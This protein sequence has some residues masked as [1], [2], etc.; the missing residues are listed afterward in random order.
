MKK[1]LA[2][3]AVATM[4]AACTNEEVTQVENLKDTPITI[5]SAG[6]GELT[7]SRTTT[8]DVVNN[9]FGLFVESTS[10]DAKYEASNMKWTHNNG[11]KSNETLLFEGAGKQTAYAYHP[12][13]ENATANYTFTTNGTTDL[14]WWKSESTLTGNSLDI[15]FSHA[16]SKLTVNLKKSSE[17]GTADL[18]DVTIGGTVLTGTADLAEQTWTLDENAVASNI[19]TTATTAASGYD[20]TVEVL[21]LP[22]TA[23][24]SVA[25]A[26]G[27]KNY[28]WT[29]AEQ[30]FASGKAYT[31]N[32]TVGKDVTAVTEVRVADWGEVQNIEGGMAEEV[33]LLSELTSTYVINDSD[34]HHFY[35]SGNYGIKVE[36]GNPTII[37]DNV[38]ITLNKQYTN[39]ENGIDIVATNSTTT[40]KVVG[41]DNSITAS[42]GAGIYVASGS[43]VMIESDGTNN[44][45][46]A[47]AGE[48]AADGAG[49]GSYGTNNGCGNITIKN[50]TIYANAEVQATITPGIGSNTETCGTIE[51]NNAIVY[52]RGTNDGGYSATPAIGA[53]SVPVI[54]ID[55]STIYA[56]RGGYSNNT[57]YADWI[58][59]IGSSGN[60]S[61]IQCG[62][63]GYIKNS[64]VN[65]YMYL[66]GKTDTIIDEGSV[67]Y[68]EN[69]EVVTQ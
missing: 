52:A 61:T 60:E 8:D 50:I 51:I 41:N 39:Y 46:V 49:I 1:Y 45:L 20:K 24:F 32:L 47:Q 30:T 28:I 66:T 65:K 62:N 69:G 11:W 37:L 21:L 3:A 16:L 34:T 64:T 22:Q 56:Y 42:R 26:A 43:T 48:T 7:A 68:N 57:S 15:E 14:L 55:N 9:P 4:F 31:L 10:D 19:A 54:K 36:S 33:I 23:T 67:T 25:I 59:K 27:D 5:A 44:V 6:V 63:G 58:G 12:Y 53:E 18:G 40:I 13:A 2:F 38:N 17:V 35:G 29:S